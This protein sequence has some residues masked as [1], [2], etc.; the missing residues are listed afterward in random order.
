MSKREDLEKKRGERVGI[1]TFHCADNFGAVLQAY[2][3]LTWLKGQGFD[4]FIVNYVPPVLRGREWLIPYLPCK[5]LR[6]RLRVSTARFIGNLR[7]GR[8]WWIRSRRF[9]TFRRECL[10]GQSRAFYCAKAL[11]W[12]KA[13]LLIVGSDQIWSPKILFGLRP[14][15]FGAFKNRRIR[16]TVAYAASFGTDRLPEDLG[17]E[18]SR[19]LSAVHEIS[20]RERGAAEYIEERFRR[21]AVHVMDPVFLL[22]PSQWRAVMDSPEERGFILSY[23]AERSQPLREA[24]CRL[25]EERHAEAVM[26]LQRFSGQES[27]F[28]TV[29]SAGPRQFLGY[30]AA[31]EYVFT[32]SFHGAAFSILFHRPFC[33]WNYSAAEA[34]IES[35]L[36]SVG[37]TGRMA[38]EGR[39]PDINEEISWEEVDRRL[40]AACANSREFLLRSLRT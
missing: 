14:A 17:P 10:T 31:A 1:L 23:E 28:R 20:M 25:A 34:R 21:K 26:L 11:S 18:F 8:D 37:L 39:M 33:V 13:D 29:Y 7:A 27:S 16:K 24:A 32:N 35:L 36:Q 2:G 4:P 3:L 38:A 6:A 19:L 22:R 15:Y 9:R 30:F 5:G 12:I 40:D